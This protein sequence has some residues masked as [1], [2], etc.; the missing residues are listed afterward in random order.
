MLFAAAGKMFK[1][2]PITV[3]AKRTKNFMLS[4]WVSRK[5]IYS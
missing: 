5:T 4:A 1:F 3:T 2:K